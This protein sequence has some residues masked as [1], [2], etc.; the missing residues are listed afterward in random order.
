MLDAAID[1]E[2]I[3]APRRAISPVLESM[4]ATREPGTR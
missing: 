2:A 4:N 3:A 1:T